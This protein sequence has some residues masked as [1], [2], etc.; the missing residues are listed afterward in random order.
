MPAYY[1]SSMTLPPPSLICYPTPAHLE[2]GEGN[3]FAM[4][5]LLSPGWP[6]FPLWPPTNVPLTPPTA[7]MLP[8]HQP[9]PRLCF[10]KT[11]TPSPRGGLPG[12]T[13]WSLHGP[14]TSGMPL[15]NNPLLASTLQDLAYV[16][17]AATMADTIASVTSD[18][19]WDWAHFFMAVKDD[20]VN[21]HLYNATATQH[22]ILDQAFHPIVA[23]PALCYYLTGKQDIPADSPLYPYWCYKC[24]RVSHWSWEHDSNHPYWEPGMSRNNR[25][26]AEPRPSQRETA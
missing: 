2:A 10:S 11:A 23:S 22:P 12:S 13:I 5:P 9:H 6:L 14:G 24:N 7:A 3:P 1:P 16:H 15:P 25:A 4:P 18:S 19:K 26:S 21:H 17:T 8:L 20:P